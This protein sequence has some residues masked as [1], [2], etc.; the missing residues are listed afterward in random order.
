MKNRDKNKDNNNTILIQVTILDIT[1]KYKPIS[2]LIEVESVDY[3]REHKEE[4]KRKAYQK[5]CNQRGITGKELVKLGYRKTIARNYTLYKQIQ[6]A[7]IE[8]KKQEHDK[9]K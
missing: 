8:R 3:F 7:K 2:T 1:G 4:C 9:E 5:I 6:E